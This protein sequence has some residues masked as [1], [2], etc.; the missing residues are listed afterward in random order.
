MAVA[1]PPHFL[2][3]PF[4]TPEERGQLSFPPQGLGMMRVAALPLRQHLPDRVQLA[5]LAQEVL[6]AELPRR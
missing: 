6:A 2:N 1:A 5:M 3:L 4:M